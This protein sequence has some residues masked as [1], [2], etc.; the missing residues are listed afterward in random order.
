MERSRCESSGS[1]P[2]DGR[3]DWY[4]WKGPDDERTQMLQVSFGGLGCV[5]LLPCFLDLTCRLRNDN[6]LYVVYQ[7]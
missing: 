7:T 4:F 3:L 1:Q 6:L 2:G 5:L